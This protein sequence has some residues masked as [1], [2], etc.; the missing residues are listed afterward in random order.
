MALLPGTRVGQYEII[1]AIGAGGMGEVYRA[2]D[3]RLQRDVAI[4]VL[5]PAF[6]EDSERLARFEHE[7]RTASSLNHPNILTIFEIAESASGRHIVSELV[8]GETLRAKL[9]RQ[10]GGLVIEECLDIAVQIASGLATAHDA[11]IVHRD[12]KPENIVVRHD[13][14]VKIL[15]F[16]LAKISVSSALSDNS[17]TSVAHSLPGMISGTV[18][19]MS[20]EQ[21]RGLAVD[22][23]SDVFSFGIL[24]YEL[25]TG[26]PPF[27]GDTTTDVLVSIVDRHPPPCSRMRPQIPPALERIVSRCLEK[28]K[29][30]RYGSARSL[31]TDLKGVID[32]SS[33]QVPAVTAPATIAVLPFADRSPRKDQDYF[34]EGI[35]EELIN[36]LGRIQQIRVASRTAAFLFKGAED[37]HTIG[38]KL[39]VASVLEGSVRTDGTRLR[40]TA[41][42]VSVADGFQLWSERFDRSMEDVFDVQ[43]EIALAIVAAL[44]VKLLGDDKAAIVKRQTNNVEAYHLCLRARYHFYRWTQDAFN[45]AVGLFEQALQLDPSYALPHFGL[46]DCQNAAAFMG[47]GDPGTQPQ[48]AALLERAVELDPTLAEAH[49]ILGINQGLWAWQW[50]DADRRFARAM[51]AN[52]L[53]PHACSA[54]GE[55]LLKSG[56][57]NQAMAF[58][59]RAVEIDPLVSMWVM[60]LALTHY[61]LKEY[62]AA[63]AQAQATLEL[64]PG[65]WWA[66]A[67]AGLSWAALGDTEQAMRSMEKAI[68]H[69]GNLPYVAGW[70]GYVQA[71][72]GLHR[73]AEQKLQ[74]MT[75]QANSGYC[76]AV[77]IASICCGL[78]RRDDCFDWLERAFRQHDPQLAFHLTS[79]SVLDDVRADDRFTSLRNRLGLAQ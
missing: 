1:A 77:A 58:A 35:A 55:Y 59:K 52:P 16:G 27:T 43:D 62:Q 14:L 25:L 45:K 73:E 36:A 40:V 51:E 53:S 38:Q 23:R 6:A 12:I 17:P 22:L 44:K 48:V 39:G 68:S 37:I 7:A 28:E 79:S 11:G 74:L 15:D 2:H 24:L 32:G 66:H 3:T 49:A 76:P 71:K 13:S 63:I 46:G 29:E 4:K 42:L 9:R 20:P 78:G 54:Y 64:D 41:Q 33:T 69:S 18:R 72:A 60:G 70:G 57:G 75:D 10:A 8:V 21:A 61:G 26:T 31:R 67:F 5:P 34:C 65:Y 56:R 19:Y 30:R 50:A 47:L